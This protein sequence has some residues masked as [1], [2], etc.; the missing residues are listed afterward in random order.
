ME[1]VVNSKCPDL[2]ANPSMFPAYFSILDT[3]QT[4]GVPLMRHI[5]AS[6]TPYC[7]VAPKIFQRNDI[8]IGHNLKGYIHSFYFVVGRMIN[9]A[10][11]NLNLSYSGVGNHCLGQFANY[12]NNVCF[13]R[14]INLYM[15]I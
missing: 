5:P 10:Y 8:E 13:H 15:N 1:F 4:S 6:S 2:F 14:N 7:I 12:T 9:K 11:P 3:S